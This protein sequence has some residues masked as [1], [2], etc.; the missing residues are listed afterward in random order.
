MCCLF[1][2]F[3]FWWKECPN[4]CA[5]NFIKQ[6]IHKLELLSAAFKTTLTICFTCSPNFQC[7]SYPIN[8]GWCINQLLTSVIGGNHKARSCR[9]FRLKILIIV[10]FWDPNEKNSHE[11]KCYRLSIFYSIICLDVSISQT[12]C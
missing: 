5:E 11:S 1:Q 6:L 4:N 8:A 7:S 10:Q 2:K 3:K 9:F 12:L